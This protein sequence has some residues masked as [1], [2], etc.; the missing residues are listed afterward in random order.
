LRKPYAPAFG[1]KNTHLLP[2]RGK[3]CSVSGSALL[4]CGE[5]PCPLRLQTVFSS[6]SLRRVWVLI[7]LGQSLRVFDALS[8]IYCTSCY[9]RFLDASYDN[10]VIKMNPDLSKRNFRRESC[11]SHASIFRNIL[12]YLIIFPRFYT[13][14]NSKSDTWIHKRESTQSV[15]PENVLTTL[16]S[17]K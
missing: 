5:E 10:K 6:R 13:I 9:H 8:L 4:S 2:Q 3:K 1:F 14:A 15:H 11:F 7:S 12:H 17:L 16:K